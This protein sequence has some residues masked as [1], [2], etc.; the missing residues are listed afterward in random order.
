MERLALSKASF[1]EGFDDL[2]DI[3]FDSLFL[4]ISSRFK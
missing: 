3:H 1:G 4:S 2:D